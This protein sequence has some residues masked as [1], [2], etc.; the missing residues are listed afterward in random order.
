MTSVKQ[1]AA[2]PMVQDASRVT[3]DR[4]R[5]RHF[6]SRKGLVQKKKKKRLTT[7]TTEPTGGEKEGKQSWP[8]R[9]RTVAKGKA[10]LLRV[11]LE[12]KATKKKK[13]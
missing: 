3:P 1:S 8:R 12:K 4:G 6:K 7:K 10:S 5:F 11:E 13:S 2:S 9:V